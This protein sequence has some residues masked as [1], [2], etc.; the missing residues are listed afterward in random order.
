[1]TADATAAERQARQR[2]RER[3]AGLKRVT[4]TVP[5]ERA[6]ELVALV[7]QWRQ[8]GDAR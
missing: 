7:K 8:D 4:V 1:V 2:E 5:E 3:A 6:A